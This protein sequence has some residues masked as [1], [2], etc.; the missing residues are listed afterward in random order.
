MMKIKISQAVTGVDRKL[1][2]AM[3]AEAIGTST[4]YA[5]PPTFAYNIGEFSISKD[6]VV[7]FTL[8]DDE[9]L[10]ELKKGFDALASA[11]LVANGTLS[12]TVHDLPE[13]I[14]NKMRNVLE[15]KLTIIKNAFQAELNYIIEGNC[16]SVNLNYLNPVLSGSRIIA[17]AMFISK[18]AEFAQTLKYVTAIERTLVNEKY[19][20]RC[21]LIRLG[22]KGKKYKEIRKELLRNLN[23]NSAFKNKDLE[24][25]DN[26]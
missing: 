2:A 5:G 11:G 7:T 3:I 4:S 10:T 19:A 1:V 16:T 14:A 22:L 12:L 17:A 21:F 26:D 15:S 25:Q 20:L 23:G 8:P 18:L 9:Y 13:P 24:V 6:S